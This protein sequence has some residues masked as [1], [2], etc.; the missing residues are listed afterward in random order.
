[1]QSYSARMELK[2]AT[3][4]NEI[5]IIDSLASVFFVIAI[6]LSFRNYNK[7]KTKDNLW[8]IIGINF[9]FLLMMAISNVLEWGGIT[10]ALD[11]AE[12]FIAIPVII[13]WVYIFSTNA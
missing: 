5:V 8:L 9:V 6:A 1:M 7:S 10:T 4:V 2:V 12:D 11:P 13:V 3:L